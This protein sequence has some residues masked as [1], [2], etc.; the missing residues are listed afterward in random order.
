MIVVVLS[1]IC[2]STI[3]LVI[4]LK[5]Y[6]VSLPLQAAAFQPF[7]RAHAHLD[8]KRREPWLFDT[9]TLRIIRNV[10]R[11]RYQYL[12][13][14]YTLFYENELTGELRTIG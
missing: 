6:I 7:M 4:D 5:S 12:P 8:T 10:I 1:Y 3:T 13:L 14:W 11:Q 9:E 2:T